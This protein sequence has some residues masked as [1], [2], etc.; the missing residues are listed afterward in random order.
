M[1]AANLAKKVRKNSCIDTFSTKLF[2][3][4][5]KTIYSITG[6]INDEELD[7]IIKYKIFGRDKS[8]VKYINNCNDTF[9][10]NRYKIYLRYRITN[11]TDSSSLLYFRLRYGSTLYRDKFNSKIKKCTLT[12]DNPRYI[13]ICK[14]LGVSLAKFIQKHG[15]IDGTEKWDNL[16][17]RNK[18]NNSIER[19]IELYGEEKGLEKWNENQYKLKNKNTLEYHKE[20]FGSI[21]GTNKYNERNKKNSESSKI[22]AKTKSPD[23]FDNNSLTS[24]I[25]RE[26]VTVGTIKYNE[27]IK[28]LSI[29]SKI[30]WEDSEYIEKH[31]N[32]MMVAQPK[33]RKTMEELGYWFPLESKTDFETYCRL[34]GKITNSQ[35]IDTL[36]DSEKRGY[37]KNDQNAYELDHVISKKYGFK[38]SIPPYIIGNISNLQFIHWKDNM[39]KRAQCYSFIKTI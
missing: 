37:R 31:K 25:G 36:S 29:S 8:I 12:P 16:C 4:D 5:F 1:T 28:N 2:D 17:E 38:N 39:T 10:I 11:K 20:R 9:C 24:F 27:M 18:G 15:T 21:E 14:S 34:V 22:F 30:H 13:E 23:F 26:G 6:K 19:A 7:E 35:N 3:F 32:S 33:I